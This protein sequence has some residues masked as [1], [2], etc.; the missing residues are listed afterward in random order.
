MDRTLRASAVLAAVLAAALGTPT[1][2]RAQWGYPG[3]YGGYGWG[4]WGGGGST[5][6]GSYARGLGV[7]AAGAGMYNEQT[8]VARSINANT[9]MNW[10]QYMYESQ[11]NANKTN[12]ERRMKRKGENIKY[13]DQIQARLRDNPN[14]ADIDSGDALNVAM[15]EVNDPRVYSRALSAAKARVGGEAIRDIPFQYATEAITTSVHQITQGGAPA[16]LKTPEFQTLRG[17]LKDVAGQIRKQVDDGQKPDPALVDK[18]LKLVEQAEAKV[19]KTMTRNSREWS[20]SQKF[21]KA[22]HGLLV[23]TEGPAINVLMAG[24][25]K[26]RPDATLGELLNFMNAFN[27]RFGAATTPRQRQVYRTLYPMLVD[28]R[29][30]AGPAVASA[31]PAASPGAAPDFFSGMDVNDIKAKQRRGPTPPPVPQP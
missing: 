14:Q 11:M 15:D 5:V 4:G 1:P 29:S 25:E 17:E 22:V 7:Y 8:A 10:N 21:L 9:V 27:L 2:A 20:E 26:K 30:Q 28:L 24:V 13:R 16:P 31:A 23:M 19:D 3:G 6:G 18:A 12:M